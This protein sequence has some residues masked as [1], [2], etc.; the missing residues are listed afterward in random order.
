M[1]KKT[2]IMMIC[3]IAL[4]SC[5]QEYFPAPVFD[6]DP[7]F[8]KENNLEKKKVEVS[9]KIRDID[10]PKNCV[11][12]YNDDYS[13]RLT[14]LRLKTS[15]QKNETHVY[16]HNGIYE[17]KAPYVIDIPVNKYQDCA[18]T[19]MYVH[20]LAKDKY[21]T[22]HDG[23][24]KRYTI[25]HKGDNLRS[26]GSCN[27]WSIGKYDVRRGVSKHEVLP[28]DMFLYGG[29]P[30]HVSIV[31]DV[32]QDTLTEHKYIMIGQGWLPACDFHVVYDTNMKDVWFNITQ[33]KGRR[34]DVHTEHT[35]YS[36]D[37]VHDLVRWKDR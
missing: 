16:R 32:V 14:S 26:M 4:A 35:Y 37:L 33:N 28:G 24:G 22:V 25:K 7:L 34:I 21:I 12:L 5:G 13:L 11:R 2:F 20:A 31:L 23:N 8:R 19:A 3:A 36:F 29:H 17:G 27:S 18:A 30:G 1:K 6:K 9:H 10:L 15:N